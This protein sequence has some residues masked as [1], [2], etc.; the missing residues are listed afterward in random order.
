MMTSMGVDLGAGDLTVTFSA[1]DNKADI[2]SYHMDNYING[3][4]KIL[5]HM[6]S[7]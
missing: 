3:N 7:Y 4:T 5:S 2:I 6:Y 1:Y